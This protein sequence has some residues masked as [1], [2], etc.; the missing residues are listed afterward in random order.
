MEKEAQ[1]KEAVVE[2]KALEPQKE[3]AV[4]HTHQWEV[5]MKT[6]APPRKNLEGSDEKT[7]QKALFGVTVLVWRCVVCSESRQEEVLGSDENQ[8]DELLEK[9]EA[10]GPQYLQKEGITFV[11]AKYQPAPLP[12]T[13]PLR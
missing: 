6:Y 7:L 3:I 4:D 11:V 10:Y 9:V 13:L 2:N 8:L 12:T 1:R 5:V